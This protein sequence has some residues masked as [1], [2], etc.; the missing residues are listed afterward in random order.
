[1]SMPKIIMYATRFCPYCMMARRLLKKK[2]VE[3][4]EIRVDGNA[5]LWQEMEERTGRHT[6][7][8]IFIG[9][10]HVGGYDDLSQ[11]EHENKLD[12]LLHA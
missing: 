3:F 5:D 9:D 11:L 2:G 10:V 4:E 12:E 1:M 8:Q 6:V 7:P